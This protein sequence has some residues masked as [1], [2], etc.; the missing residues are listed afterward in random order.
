MAAIED[1]LTPT[2]ALVME[3]LAARF[4]LGETSWPMPDRV[5]PALKGL[6]AKGLLSF[7]SDIMP[8]Y[9]RA[10]MTEEGKKIFM[11]PGYIPPILE[12]LGVN[13]SYF[14]ARS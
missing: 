12:R 9:Q 4:R 14:R 3:V 11:R 2:E 10:T 6:A 13:R 5:K 1:D 7:Q 8:R